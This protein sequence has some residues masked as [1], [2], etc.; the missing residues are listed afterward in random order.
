MTTAAKHT[1]EPW[2]TNGSIVRTVDGN[3][4]TDRK[5][6]T[7]HGDFGEAE[8]IAN[9]RLIAAAPDLLTALRDLVEVNENHNESIAKIIG[10]PLTW[11]DD[12]LDAARA[13]I[14]KAEGGAA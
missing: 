5:I 9:A 4:M 12:Y 8:K 14:A 1:A 3:N 6:A 13:A 11:K 2:T 10:K 7:V